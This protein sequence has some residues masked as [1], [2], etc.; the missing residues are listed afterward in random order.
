MILLNMGKILLYVFFVI[1]IFYFVQDRFDIFDISFDEGEKIGDIIKGDET[2]KEDSV[3]IYN[4]EGK[5]VVVRVD[6][7]DEDDERVQGLSGRGILG[8]YE[9]MLFVMDKQDQYGFWMKDMLI[10]L[11]FIFIDSEGFIVDTMEK[12][13]PCTEDECP[14]FSADSTF[15]YVIE[16]NSGFIENNRIVVG[17]SVVFNISSSLN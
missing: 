6:V 11:D 1:V 5:A 4:G 14:S 9:G 10:P 17:N 3:E 8:D 16:V 7:A 15:K 13:Q 2:P 12:V